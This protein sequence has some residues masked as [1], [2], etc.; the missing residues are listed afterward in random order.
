MIKTAAKFALNIVDEKLFVPSHLWARLRLG[1]PHRRSIKTDSVDE[2]LRSAAGWLRR[3]YRAA[4]EKGV[5]AR[6]TFKSGWL[7]A[8]PETT[9]YLIPTLFNYSAYSNDAY[10]RG[11]AYA[12]ADWLVEI[13]DPSGGF[14][15]GHLDQKRPPVVFN[16]GQ[17]LIGLLAAYRQS[18]SSRY[19]DA[20][21]R[22]GQWLKD[23]QD[24]DGAWRKNTYKDRLHAYHTRVAWPLA[25]LGL[26]SGEKSFV[27]CARANFDFTMTLQQGNGWFKENTLDEEPVPFTHT[28]AY[29]TR[30]LLEGGL[31]LG[32]PKNVESAKKLAYTLLEDFEGRGFLAGQYD[33]GYAPRACFSCLTGNAQ[34]SIIWLKLGL[35]DREKRKRLI[36]AAHTINRQVM[37]CQDLFTSNAGIRGAVPGSWPIRGDYI[38]YGYP[39]WAAK[40]LIDALL[41]EKEVNGSVTPK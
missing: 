37:H 15:G 38:R 16:T 35:L 13:Q 28:L 8:Y 12:L 25:D 7:S 1:R 4:D 27:D 36:N 20:A 32:E 17:I 41:L 31:L 11:M 30:G 19:F 34:M 24:E 29:V 18:K 2:H 33:M 22:A 10:F 14:A 26:L 6:Y 9:G 5:A 21:F 23:V 40:F 39:N 3:A